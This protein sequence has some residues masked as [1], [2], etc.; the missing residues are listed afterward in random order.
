MSNNHTAVIRCGKY[1]SIH[2]DSGMVINYPA[3]HYN[4]QDRVID[5]TGGGNSYL[6]GFITGLQRTNDINIAS[7]YGN[8]AAGCAIEQIGMPDFDVVAFKW[9]GKTLE[10][11]VRYYVETYN[12]NLTSEE[13][14]SKLK[15]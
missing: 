7:V 5:P 13:V 11:R 8:V 9:N 1:G 3:Y 12:I 6:G 10:E 14:L 15:Y 2:F 4:S